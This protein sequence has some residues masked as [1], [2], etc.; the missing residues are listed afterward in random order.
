MTG[1]A[2]IGVFAGC[3]LNTYLINQVLP[4]EDVRARAFPE[5]A[6]EL[7][8][9]LANAAASMPMRVSYTFNLTGPS[10][11]Q[12]AACATGLVA[13]HS[14]R[15]SLLA[16]ECDMALAGAAAVRMPPNTPFRPEPGMILARDGMCRAFDRAATGTVYGDGVGVVLLKR[17]HD[18]RRDGDPIHAVLLG[19]AVNNDGSARLGFAAPSVDGQAAVLSAAL[20][21]ADID[22]SS[23]GYVEAHGTGTPLGD[24]VE[25]AALTLAY[26]TASPAGSRQHGGRCAIG[27]VKTRIGHC[28]EAAGIAGLIA[29]V[30]A[31][32][33]RT[34]P[35]TR[36]FTAPNPQIKLDAVPFT[37]STE[38]RPWKQAGPRRAGVSAFG[39]GGTNAH[40]I[41][42]EAPDP[43][44]AP[45][46][47]TVAVPHVLPLS[48]RSPAGLRTLTRRFRR[49]FCLNR[50]MRLEDICF[51]AAV[52]RRSYPWRNA[53]VASSPREL[54]AKLRAAESGAPGVARR[55]PP[56]IAF[57]F[58]GAAPGLTGS[59]RELYGREPVFREAVERCDE[60][61][62][63][64]GAAEITPRGV[65]L[66]A[67]L[68][69]GSEMAQAQ[70]SS[71]T[72]G[73][74]LSRMWLDW[75]VRPFAVLGHG[76]GEYT[77]ACVAGVF[78][79]GFGV[80]MSVLTNNVAALAALANGLLPMRKVALLEAERR[81]Q[82]ELELKRSGYSAAQPLGVPSTELL[83]SPVSEPDAEDEP[84]ALAA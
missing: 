36:N 71:F 19:S 74:A 80:G 27:S 1:A 83:P 67:P 4:S 69:P 24:P 72:L 51:S 62:R 28:A 23:I 73:Y 22:P 7:Q 38:R 33:N 59:G 55:H 49:H 16:G 66:G 29:A 2:K 42:E 79:L 5:T 57:L 31:L 84:N 47:T 37:I 10:V 77:A 34:L 53:I 82:L 15:L 81:H 8:I 17:L 63:D 25:I 78:T 30:L 3:G 61:V 41:L 26:G 13:V 60:I 45:S 68:T 56:K 65:L 12:Q 14:A 50:G 20:R 11:T 75:S 21:D 58:A 76:F 52:L 48:A 32:K 9:L 43:T 6:R 44:A 54:R 40:A 46:A 64:L 70:V 18:A 39:M 35:A